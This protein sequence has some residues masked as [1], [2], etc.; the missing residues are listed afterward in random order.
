MD[1]PAADRRRFTVSGE[2][3][4]GKS[5]VAKLLAERTGAEYH[6]TGS[7]QRRLA[8]GRQLSTLE[9]NLVSE[10]EPTIDAEIDGYTRELAAGDS[11]FVIDSRLAWHFVP[12]ALRVFLLVDTERA[13]ARVLGDQRSRSDTERYRGADQAMRDI[14]AR[15]ESERRR[16]LGTYGVDLFRWS[17]YDL[18]IDTSEISAEEAVRLILD[19]PAGLRRP[20]T[21]L[22]LAPRSLYP[23]EHVRLLAGAATD[24]L[25]AAMGERGFDPGAPIR[26]V[27]S[28]RRALYVLDGHRRLSCALRLGLDVVPCELAGQD[29]DEIVPDLSV[30]ALV[31][32]QPRRSWLYDWEAAHD[33][34]YR[35]YPEAG[36]DRASVADPEP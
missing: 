28:G 19:H 9:L 32:A 18:I 13:A 17:N 6:S 2:I 4:S 29:G 22:W 20:P 34:R 11:E 23:T 12:D 33:F 30:E 10:Q 21:R 16:F 8:S 5:S 3:G 27:A 35:S 31:A 25:L 24:E 15:Q 7:L 1:S 36:G 14:V 26:V